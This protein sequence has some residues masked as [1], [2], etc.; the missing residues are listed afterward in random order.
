M[1]SKI[2]FWTNGALTT[3]CLAYYLQKKFDS[4]FYTIID[5]YDNPKSFFQHQQLVKFQKTWFYHDHFQDTSKHDLEYLSNFEKKYD[6]NLWEL[7]INE[8]IFYKF[9]SIHN[10]SSDEILSI[11]EHECKLFDEIITDSSPD[12]LIMFEP[13]LHQE[14]LL[15]RMCKK[16][17]IKILLLTQPNI[18]RF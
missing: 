9:N 3:F 7:A 1:P 16:K 18:S 5:T 6:I 12:F 15:Y 11:L 17:G 10:F 14:E 4:D 13:T 2:L 8:R